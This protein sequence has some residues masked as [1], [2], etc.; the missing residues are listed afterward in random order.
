[1]P[2]YALL[3]DI[4]NADEIIAVDSSNVTLLSGELIPLS[5]F[6]TLP[7][8]DIT[9][10]DYYARNLV[11]D[12]G[13]VP[14][15][16]FE[17]A[18]I[19]RREDMK[20]LDSAVVSSTTTPVAI[21]DLSLFVQ[22]NFQYFYLTTLYFRSS[23]IPNGIS[24]TLNGPSSFNYL[25]LRVAVATGPGQAADVVSDLFEDYGSFVD[26]G[27]VDVID[28][29]YSATLVMTL[30]NGSNSGLLTPSFHSEGL[31]AI[32]IEVG[33]IAYQRRV[34]DSINF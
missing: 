20:V 3:N 15:L 34:Y 29:L 13:I 17:S 9:I 27:G 28:K 24:V 11:H 19:R 10:G 8:T 6:P 26:G 23:A 14:K 33:S 25:R 2:Q 30:Y 31:G 18:Y 5:N 22:P 12:F 16:L 21:T 32:T 1:M 7:F 4:V